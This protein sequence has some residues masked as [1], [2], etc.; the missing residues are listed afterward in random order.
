MGKNFFNKFQE[1]FLNFFIVLIIFI[2]LIDFSQFFNKYFFLPDFLNLKFK[3]GLDLAGGSILTY[4]ADLSN[5]KSEE[6]KETMEI[7]KDVIERRVNLF[8]INEPKVSYSLTENSGRLYVELP[9]IKSPQEAIEKIGETPYLEFYIPQ[10]A[11]DSTSTFNFVPS[12]LTGRYLKKAQ[13]EYVSGLI[14]PVVTLNFD[15]EGAKIFKELTQKYLEQPIAIVLDGQIISSPVVKE[16]IENGNAQITGKFSLKE[17]QQLAR[18]LNEGTL[19][20]KMEI[21]GHQI[22]SGSYG[23][24]FINLIL[25]SSFWVFL[26]IAAFMILYYKEGGIISSIALFVYAL[27]NI[28]VYKIFGVVLTLAG[29]VGFILSIGMAIDAN[30]LILERFKEEKKAGKSGLNLINDSFERAWSS[31]RDSNITTLISSIILY[32]LTT[33]FVRGFA[34]TL[35]IGVLISMFT[36]VFFTRI[37]MI[38]VWVR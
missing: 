15:E 31:I 8:G 18:R 11:T 9:G 36:A 3:L 17:A 21:F 33:S 25:K 26:I 37:L 35:S 22:I 16:V 32:F 34:L 27:L 14:E 2:I 38:K 30:I 10:M 6:R 1:N 29:I 13:V 23:K 24:D 19:P 7:L 5:I 12:G 20:V 4:S 28:F